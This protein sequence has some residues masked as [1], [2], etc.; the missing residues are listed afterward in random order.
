MNCDRALHARFEDLLT[1]YDAQ[2][3]HLLAFLRL[4][5]SNP[6]IQQVIDRYRPE[7]AQPDRKA[8]ISARARLVASA[9]K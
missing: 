7:K 5:R 2:V 3:E 4:D 6:G 9:K 1:D 8:S